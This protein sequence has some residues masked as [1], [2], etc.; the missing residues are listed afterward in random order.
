MRGLGGRWTSEAGDGQSRSHCVEMNHEPTGKCPLAAR[1]VDSKAHALWP[2][3]CPV[4]QHG[5]RFSFPADR[6]R[7][8]SESMGSTAMAAGGSSP[9]TIK[10]SFSMMWRMTLPSGSGAKPKWMMKDSRPTEV[11]QPFISPVLTAILK[12][13]AT[14][15]FCLA[16]EMAVEPVKMR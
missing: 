3:R 16:V 8:E 13:A 12:R 15:L 5:A 7:V 1:H 6:S 14:S 9:P 2:R 10:L 4:V 11:V